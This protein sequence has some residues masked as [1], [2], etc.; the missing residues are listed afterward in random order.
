MS[1]RKTVVIR[2]LFQNVSIGDE[3]KI[4]YQLLFTHGILVIL[5]LLIVATNIFLYNTMDNDAAIIN[6]SG[7]MRALNYN[8]SMLANQMLHE[9]DPEKYE[10]I[11]NDLITKQKLFENSLIIL[12]DEK[13]D[14]LTYKKAHKQL[15]SIMIT[16]QSLFKPMYHEITKSKPTQ[17][18]INQLNQN[19]DDYVSQIDE[20]VSA[21]SEYSK[22]KVVKSML[23]N[24]FLI[25]VI[26]MVTLYSFKSTSKHIGRP[27]D[28]LITELKEL[29]LIDEDVSRRLKNIETSEISEMSLYMNEMMFDQL[30]KVYTRKAGLAK[31]GKLMSQHYRTNFILSLCFIDINGLKIV[32]DVLGHKQGDRLIEKSINVIKNEIRN[33]DFIIRMGGDEFLIV[34]KGIN[35]PSTEQIWQRINQKYMEINDKEKEPFNISVSHGVVAFDHAVKSELDEWIRH[36]D[37]K[38]YIE[39]RIIKEDQNFKV[40]K[41]S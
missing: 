5:A 18:I 4:K 25:I 26:L 39:K 19:I 41:N 40:I 27:M 8:M 33:D 9:E 30:T 10:L 13:S 31:L 37:D 28:V 17:K 36:A 1:L 24:A 20:M 7:R 23:A 22:N 21:Y 11:K 34:F 38:M 32:N 16:W 2:R 35:Q 6:Q 29:S 15:E 3:M 12:E 14:G